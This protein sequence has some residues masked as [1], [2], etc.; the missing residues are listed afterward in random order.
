MDPGET[1]KQA[2]E[3]SHLAAVGSAA[4]KQS[5]AEAATDTAA[6]FHLQASVCSDDSESPVPKEHTNSFLFF[7]SFS[8]FFGGG[9]EGGTGD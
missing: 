9:E 3:G 4:H 7:F 1:Q 6:V 8:F 2:Q 5:Q